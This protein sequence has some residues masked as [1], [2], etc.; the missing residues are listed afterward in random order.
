[1]SPNFK[2]LRIDTIAECLDTALELT[3]DIYFVMREIRALRVD[4]QPIKFDE[5]DEQELIILLNGGVKERDFLLGIQAFKSKR[6]W[7]EFGT[8]W[9][10]I[11]AVALR[12]CAERKYVV[13]GD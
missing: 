2:S 9:G 10:Y 1:M 7:P 6:Y 4:G 13:A 3:Q 11:R 5:V 12:T 8:D